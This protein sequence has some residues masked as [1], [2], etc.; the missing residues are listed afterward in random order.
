VLNWVQPN[1]FLM[2]WELMLQL[3]GSRYI[4]LPSS[5]HSQRYALGKQKKPEVVSVPQE[6]LT[7]TD[8]PNR[9]IKAV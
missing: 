8:K 7:K 1:G 6:P 5:K 2:V 9:S 3:H 4:K